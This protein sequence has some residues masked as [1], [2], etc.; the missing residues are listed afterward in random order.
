[1]KRLAGAAAMAAA[2]LAVVA[3]PSVAQGLPSFCNGALA[4]SQVYSTKVSDTVIEYHAVFQNRDSSPRR[5]ARL[6]VLPAYTT[7]PGWSGTQLVTS[8]TVQGGQVSDVA[9]LRMRNTSVGFGMGT[10][11]APPTATQALD[12]VRFLTCYL[13]G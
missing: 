11:P 12:F 13:T 3:T 5:T 2:T 6:T 1:M 4:M 9:F 8:V 7:T 10:P